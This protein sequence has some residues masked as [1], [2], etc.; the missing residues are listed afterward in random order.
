MMMMLLILIIFINL[1]TTYGDDDELP[2]PSKLN[3]KYH[4]VLM[5]EDHITSTQI[6]FC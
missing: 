1:L 5:E 3:N 2:Q 6:N 4:W